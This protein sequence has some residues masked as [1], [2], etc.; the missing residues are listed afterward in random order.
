MGSSKHTHGLVRVAVAAQPGKTKHFQTL[1]LPNRDDMMLCDCPG[2]VFPSFVSNTADLIAAGVYPIAQMRD[3]WPV[4]ELIC[5]RIPREIV[6]A[7]YG[8]KLPEPSPEGLQ[9]RGLK[10]VPPPTAEEFLSTYCVARNMLAASSG[11]PD[12]TRASRIV[13]KDYVSGKLLFCHA[14][15][16][17]TESGIAAFHRETV[18]TAFHNTKK[19]RDKLLAQQ[20]K[21][22]VKTNEIENAEHDKPAEDGDPAND[23]DLDLLD[24]IGASAGDGEEKK[25][26]K[27]GKAHKTRNKHGRKGRK[28]RDSDPYGCHADPDEMLKKE[29]VGGGVTVKAGKYSKK[30]YTRPTNFGG[31]RNALETNAK[32]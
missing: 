29:I 15:P 20:D 32:N 19:L 27:R 26:G 9:Q 2:L 25:G 10:N 17:V 14:P 8:I 16:N 12:Y 4:V 1:L 23:I 24:I 21:M 18:A 30:G 5:R 3:H 31:A 6:N 11:V 13:I 7:S 28:D 22:A